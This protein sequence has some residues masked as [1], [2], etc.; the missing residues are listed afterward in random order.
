[1]TRSPSSATE[2][3][4]KNRLLRRALVVLAG[5]MLVGACGSDSEK[6]GVDC[7]VPGVS[8]RCVCAGNPTDGTRTC[9]D[10][11]YWSECDCSTPYAGDT[12]GTT[13][14]ETGG[15][16]GVGVG[17]VLR[18]RSPVRSKRPLCLA[19]A[20]ELGFYFTAKSSCCLSCCLA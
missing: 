16:G 5:A 15:S 8:E 13:G 7:D 18:L 6:H 1:M 3:K 10:D 2:A 20:E 4:M 14:G 12:G 17:G 11:G 19:P 9:Q